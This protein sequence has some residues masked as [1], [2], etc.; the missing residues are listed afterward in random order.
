M[1][2]QLKKIEALSN[3]ALRKKRNCRFIQEFKPANQPL[4]TPANQPLV[5]P[6]LL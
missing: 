2:S 4:I 1:K 5:K 3:E 6:S